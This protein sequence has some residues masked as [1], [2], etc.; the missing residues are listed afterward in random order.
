M[1]SLLG[2]PFLEV[3]VDPPSQGNDAICGNDAYFI[4]LYLG[5]KSQFFDYILL[6]LLVGL[7]SDRCGHDAAPL[8]NH[9][10]YL[11]RQLSADSRICGRR[12]FACP[13]ASCAFNLAQFLVGMNSSCE[14][15]VRVASA[16][17]GVS[18]KTLAV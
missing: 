1:S 6:K 8:V 11:G 9:A 15:G 7:A 4:Y 17:S 12:S 10:W 14:R 16:I 2:T 18:S 3:R 5:V 13:D